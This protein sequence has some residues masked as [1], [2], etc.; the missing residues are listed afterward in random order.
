MFH[1]AIVAASIIAMSVVGTNT[2]SARN[3]CAGA[4]EQ[5][6][7]YCS[8]ENGLQA[9]AGSSCDNNY[10]GYKWQGCE[11]YVAGYC[12]VGGAPGPAG[13]K[14][15]FNSISNPDP[16]NTDPN[17]QTGQ[18]N[19]G[20]LV[21]SGTVTCTFHVGGTGR[22][23]DNASVVA[24]TSASGGPVVVLPPT[25]FSYSDDYVTVYLCTSWTDS[26]RTVYWVPDAAP[27]LGAWSTNGGGA[28]S[29]VIRDPG[30]I[31]NVIND[32]LESLDPT[33]CGLPL[34]L[35][36]TVSPLADDPS[37]AVYIGPDGDIYVGGEFIYDCPPYGG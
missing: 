34:T 14:C 20:P 3:E 7:D 18:I 6:C 11:Y 9:Q 29:A 32:I 28:C 2:A 26:N 19:A 8:Y 1:R 4:V 37:G 36:A 30:P 13:R 35:K 27:G 10:A 23:N 25:Q 31:A 17:A 24:A 16:N 15:T 5:N 21:G 22:H 33:I 12:V